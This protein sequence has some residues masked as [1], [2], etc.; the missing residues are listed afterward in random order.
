MRNSHFNIFYPFL[1]VG[2]FLAASQALLPRPVLA[3]EILFPDNPVKVEEKV[4][5]QW[6]DFYF[7]GTSNALFFSGQLQDYFSP[8]VD[9]PSSRVRPLVRKYGY[10]PEK[11]YSFLKEAAKTS[12]KPAVEPELIIENSKVKKFTPPQAGQKTN[13]LET[14]LLIQKS[15][16]TDG[17]STVPSITELEPKQ[18]LADTN[19]WGIRE[20]IATG[21]SNFRGSPSNRRHNIK[22]GVEKV[23]G[24]LVA[25]GQEFSFNENLGP[26]EEGYGFLPE[27]VIKKS[28]TVP[29]LGGG[30]CQVSS[31]VF[32]AAIHAGLPITQRRNHAYAV[33]YYAPQGTD[34][35]IYPGIID[36]KFINDTPGYILLWAHFKE[37][38]GLVYEIYGTRDDR[39][40][41]VMPAVQYD[42]KSD[43][44]MKATW[45]REVTKNGQT[46]KDVFKSV[47]QPPALFHKQEEFVSSGPNS[48]TAPPPTP[49]P[50]TTA[51]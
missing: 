35:T 11:I 26:V 41:K 4:S 1:L 33:Q 48:T 10:S 42:R 17:T 15:L 31:T 36:L 51:N 6:K 37:K 9:L 27:L 25:P 32:R 24:I 7:S 8:K 45:E 34:A 40:V 16:E 14:T 22:V 19:A 29:E 38:D 49:T 46:K 13:L 20:L 5:D 39:E 43:G 21:E 23:N 28:G 47:Y 30:L 50:A 2:I 18:S 3:M 12:D 44:S